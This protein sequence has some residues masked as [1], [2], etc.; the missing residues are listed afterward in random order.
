[1]HRS[2]RSARAGREGQ[3]YTL[4]APGEVRHFKSVLARCEGQ[5]RTV[6]KLTWRM[7]TLQGYVPGYS[8]ALAALGKAVGDERR[9]GKVACSFFFFFFFSFCLD[10]FFIFCLTFF[11]FMHTL[12]YVQDA[13]ETRQGV[14]R[15]SKAKKPG[16]RKRDGA[17]KGDGA[18]GEK[19][20]ADTTPVSADN[21]AA[22]LRAIETAML[23]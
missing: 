12:M 3:S 15:R 2:G 20:R 13:H 1:M 5:D 23:A 9:Y 8:R 18:A 6:H 19:K 21:V 7:A 10:D 4:C 17:G 16:K 11:Y 14:Q 22:R